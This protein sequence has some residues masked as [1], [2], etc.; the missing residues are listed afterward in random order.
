MSVPVRPSVG[1]SH[2][3]VSI[4]SPSLVALCEKMKKADPNYFYILGLGRILKKW[5]KWLKMVNIWSKI[6]KKILKW[7]KMAKIA[8]VVKKIQNGEKWSSP[9]LLRAC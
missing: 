4:L 9:Q 3:R 1:R 7:S 8:K 6:V 2:F 5:Q